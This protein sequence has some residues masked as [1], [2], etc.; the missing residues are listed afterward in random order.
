[1][2]KKE[3]E[4]TKKL[5][6]DNLVHVLGLEDHLDGHSRHSMCLVMEMCEVSLESLIQER[7]KGLE[8]KGRWIRLLKKIEILLGVAQG[9]DYLHSQDTVHG[10]LSSSNVLLNVRSLPDDAVWTNYVKITD[11]GL[12]RY[13]DPLK[14]QRDTGSC[15]NKDILPKDAI[16]WQSGK[17]VLSLSEKVDVFSFG[18]LILQVCCGEFPTPGD[19]T[20]TSSE[21]EVGR[22]MKYLKMLSAAEKVVFDECIKHCLKT[23][24]F[25][26]TFVEIKSSLVHYQQKYSDLAHFED[27]VVST[28]A[29]AAVFDQ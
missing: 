9:M 17:Q 12:A 25:Q 21:M 11:F 15:G 28:H 29:H 10:D 19:F 23:K 6:H 4:T 3:F 1:M 16:S 26:S 20:G 14:R 2:A 13:I 27:I 8:A 7:S 5:R 24:E 22:R 18:C